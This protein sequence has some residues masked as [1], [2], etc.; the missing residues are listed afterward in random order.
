MKWGYVC[1]GFQ[2]ISVIMNDSNQLN[3]LFKYKPKRN[4]RLLKHFK[5]TYFHLEFPNPIK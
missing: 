2:S 1:L 5:M 4:A 3:F